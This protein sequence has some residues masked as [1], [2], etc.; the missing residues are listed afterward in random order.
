MIEAA[1][2]SVTL[3]VSV[4]RMTAAPFASVSPPAWL[5][6]PRNE[7]DVPLSPVAALPRSP[8]VAQPDVNPTTLTTF[9][10]PTEAP[11]KSGLP[12]GQMPV[13]PAAIVQP[14]A[15]ALNCGVV[16]APAPPQFGL[17]MSKLNAPSDTSAPLKFDAITATER[18]PLAGTGMSQRL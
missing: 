7:V 10:N 18:F 13:T 15:A 12:T 17:K 16:V 8:P 9:V 6:Q 5:K 2:V 4:A 11:V 3:Y 14:L 1:A